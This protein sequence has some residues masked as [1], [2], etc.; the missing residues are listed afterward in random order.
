MF[1]S[2]A[3]VSYAQSAAVELPKK[4]RSFFSNP[5]K[6]TPCIIGDDINQDNF[7]V[8]RG[9]YIMLKHDNEN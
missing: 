3:T 7:R 8:L 5:E 1:V 9:N 4:D 6:R 2:I